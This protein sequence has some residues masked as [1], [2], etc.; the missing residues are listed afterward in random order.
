MEGFEVI[1]RYTREDALEDGVLIDA[2]E[3]AAEVGFKIPVALTGNCWARCVA[4][5]EPL[6]G[7]QDVDGR[8]WDVLYMALLAACALADTDLV[9]FRI[10]VLGIGE[11]GYITRR[12]P[13]LWAKIGPGDEGEPV[14][15]I[16]FPHDF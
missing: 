12:E 10:S 16:G 4:V 11:A 5:P 9:T 15:T 14:I 3:Q 13:Q 2:T 6:E 7:Q 8:L 1:S